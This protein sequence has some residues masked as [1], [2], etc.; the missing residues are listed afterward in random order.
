MRLTREEALEF[1]RQMW[2]D[3]QKALGD[4][5]FP[6]ER[7]AFMHKWIENHF[8]HGTRV[9][10]DCFLCEYGRQKCNT[11]FPCAYC[12][13]AWNPYCGSA[14]CNPGKYYVDFYGL[15]D[16]RFTPISRIL[17]LLEREDV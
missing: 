13:I 10:Y 16:Y 9:L 4:N 17:A 3:M 12:P 2:T 14:G 11:L 6:N 15:K 8:P 1:H 5:P 7:F